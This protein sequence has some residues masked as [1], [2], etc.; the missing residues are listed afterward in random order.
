[1][2]PLPLRSSASQA[3]SELADVQARRTLEPRPAMSKS[4][5][6]AA[7]VRPYP[8]PLTSTMIGVVGWQALPWQLQPSPQ[9]GSAP[10]RLEAQSGPLLLQS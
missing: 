6:P 9:S 8:S 4:T 7:L 3:S 1:M 5:P 10:Q 2:A